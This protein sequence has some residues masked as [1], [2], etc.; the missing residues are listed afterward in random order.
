MW[1]IVLVLLIILYM[2]IYGVIPTIIYRIRNKKDQKL[3]EC[4]KSKD[5]YLTFDDGVDK[6]Y[7]MEV[8]KVLKEFEI[9]ATFFVVASFA[10]ENPKIV[11]RMKEDGHL[12]G[13]H[14]LNHENEILQMPLKVKKDF[15]KGID[16]LKKLGV[17]VKY[18][19]PPWG[20]FSLAGIKEIKKFN[21]KI[22][23]WDVIVQDW[24]ADTDAE[25]IAKKLLDKTTKGNIICLH[26]G[27]GKNEAPKRTIEA[28]KIVLP[29]WKS[30][31]YIFKTVEEL[32]DESWK[33]VGNN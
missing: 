8:L 7:T 3:R 19:R 31:G 14:S 9:S 26:D 24:E 16:I 17:K 32:S 11:A 27:R 18:F 2:M 15:I 20:H 6:K 21:L 28:L 13:F 29:I 22:V 12:I 30:Q 25:T 1:I 10:A 4:A 33:N 23:L 5:L